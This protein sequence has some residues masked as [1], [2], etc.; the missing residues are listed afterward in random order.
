MPSSYT[1]PFSRSSR[2][3]FSLS[4]ALFRKKCLER[5][6]LFFLKKLATFLVITV[7]H[8]SAVSSPVLP[9]F[10]FSWKKLATF[11]GHHCRFY[12]FH[13]FTHGSPIIS[14]MLQKI[15]APLVGAPFLWGPLF[16]GPLF[17]RTCW[18]CLNQPLR[19]SISS[20][21][22]NFNRIIHQLNYWWFNAFTC[23]IFQSGDIL[24]CL[25]LTVG[26][27]ELHQGED[28]YRAPNVFLYP[29]SVASF[30]IRSASNATG[31][32]NRG[33]FLSTLPSL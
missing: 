10:L 25:M 33:Q 19:L 1:V 5:H 23:P 8:P 9:I 7:C 21:I 3:G 2:A 32:E 6:T 20:I 4:L 11:F 22:V 17:G 12:S 18:T 27:T 26:D 15:A 31:V 24:I 14:G 30:R 16:V 29:R 13:S 28:H